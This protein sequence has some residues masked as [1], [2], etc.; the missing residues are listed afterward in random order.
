MTA[1]LCLAVV[2]SAC[3]ES[4]EADVRA[5]VRDFVQATNDNDPRACDELVTQRYLEQSTAERGEEARAACREQL[6]TLGGV[7]VNVEK[8][9]STRVEDDTA[10]VEVELRTAGVRDSRVIELARQDGRWQ[11]DGGQERR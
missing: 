9:T 1:L 8:F 6:K 3:G 4:E 5:A 10:V 11:L 2:V 7:E